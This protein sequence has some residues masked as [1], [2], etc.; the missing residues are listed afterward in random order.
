MKTPDN[1]SKK[2]MSAE[3]VSQFLNVPRSTIYDLTRSGKI[4]GAKVGKH[5]RYLRDDVE[6]YLR[7]IQSPSSSRERR[8][9]PRINCRLSGK[10]ASTL[11]ER[12]KSPQE[13]WVANLSEGGVLF[14]NQMSDGFLKVGDPV[15][16]C[17]D[18]EDQG[19]IEAKGRIVHR[20]FDSHPAYGIKFRD[21]PDEAR[22]QIRKYVG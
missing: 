19:R 6:G 8:K 9:S 5:W 14:L 10:L 20:N 11:V 4:T 1:E 2:V 21:L 7:G 13:G 15:S 12:S 22:A 18:L 17:F 3:E 16:L